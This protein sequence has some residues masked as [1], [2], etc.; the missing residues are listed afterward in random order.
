MYWMEQLKV[1]L[2]FNKY[3]MKILNFFKIIHNQVHAY[4]DCPDI[5]LVGNKMDM[6]RQRVI[7]EVRARNFA[8]KYN[9]PYIETSAVTGENVKKAF[10]ILLDLVM[11]R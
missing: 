1:L 7:T 10:E 11:G 5:V 8:E 2:S 9:L 3:L 4:C 6:E